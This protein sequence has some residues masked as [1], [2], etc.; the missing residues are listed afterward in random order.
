M[1]NSLI[2]PGP[3]LFNYVKSHPMLRFSK[4]TPRILIHCPYFFGNGWVDE[5]PEGHYKSFVYFDKNLKGNYYIDQIEP[6]ENIKINNEPCHCIAFIGYS[7][8][9]VNL[10]ITQFFKY[11]DNFQLKI[12]QTEINFKLQRIDK[13][14]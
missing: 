3:K 14:F 12:K 11:L 6:I 10:S 2:I 9:H 5:Y 7:N 13:D 8:T 1:A 4:T